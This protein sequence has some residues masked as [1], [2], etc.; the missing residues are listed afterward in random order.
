MRGSPPIA[1]LAAEEANGSADAFKCRRA[2]LK[3]E[4]DESSEGGLRSDKGCGTKLADE[5]EVI[6]DSLGNW[7]MVDSISLSAAYPGVSYGLKAEIS[8][9]NCVGVCGVED[10][11]T[12]LKSLLELVEAARAI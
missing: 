10:S 11:G 4:H 5:Y 6:G 2:F 7:A 12:A 1:S 3:A 9:G 8:S